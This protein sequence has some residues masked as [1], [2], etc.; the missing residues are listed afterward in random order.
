VPNSSSDKKKPLKHLTYRVQTWDPTLYEIL[1]H[2]RAWKPTIWIGDINV[3]PDD[4]DV[5]NPKEMSHKPGFTNA[6]RE[7]FIKFVSYP[8]KLGVP[9]WVDIWR[10]QH[11]KEVAYSYRGYSGKSG[12]RLDNTLITSE[13][14]ERVIQSYILTDWIAPTDHVP[15]G[16]VMK[17]FV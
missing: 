3:A 1:E 16:I 10:H 14:V 12:L 2:M 4:I 6:E 15:I 13:L 8:N 7:S 5:S 17:P 9:S 11:P